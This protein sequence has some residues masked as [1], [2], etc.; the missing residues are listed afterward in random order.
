MSDQAKKAKTNSQGIP[1]A[2]KPLEHSD[3]PISNLNKNEAK[4]KTGVKLRRNDSKNK[5]DK[6]HQNQDDKFSMLYS[7]MDV[8]N[9]G[10]D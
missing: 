7:E 9:S 8:A 5:K 10:S 3:N 4:G 1:K 6:R 2:K